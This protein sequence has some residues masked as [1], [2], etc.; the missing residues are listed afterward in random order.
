[1]ETKVI[2]WTF[3]VI[4]GISA[5]LTLLGITGVIKT[6][7]EKYLNA[8][9]TAL[10]LEVIAAVLFVFKSYDF[11][12]TAGLTFAGIVEE[13]RIDNPPADEEE[14]KTYVINNLRA[15]AELLAMQQERD[16]LQEKSDSLVNALQNCEGDLTE[17]DNS[18]Y[19]KVTRLRNLIGTYSGSINLGFE[20]EKKE[21]TYAILKEILGILGY[22][23]GSGDITFQQIRNQYRRFEEKHGR[24]E[25]NESIIS[26]FETTLMIREYLNKY[27]PIK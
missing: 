3:I 20:A 27:Y 18:F 11:N 5:I 25:E 15:S 8:L 23:Q 16:L 13:A 19:T 12:A 9:F 2:I 6:I 14:C 24:Y 4:F 7:Q 21:V 26:E 10:I 17:L 1:M 22:L